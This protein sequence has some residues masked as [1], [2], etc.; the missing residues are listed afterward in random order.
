VARE[1]G[2][3]GLTGLVCAGFVLALA[4]LA[5]TLRDWLL[6]ALFVSWAG[7]PFLGHYAL[8]GS[9][10]RSGPASPTNLACATAAGAA[11]FVAYCVALPA[12]G[13]VRRARNPAPARGFAEAAVPWDGHRGEGRPGE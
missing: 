6:V 4:G 3:A 7:A 5:A 10:R 12:A 9:V 13:G 1:R 8:A 2:A 11:C